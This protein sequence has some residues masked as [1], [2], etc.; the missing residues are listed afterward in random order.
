M[1]MQLQSPFTGLDEIVEENFPL[2]PHTWYRI[3]G[4]A[5]YFVRPKSIEQLQQTAKRCAENSIPIYVLGLGANLL[6]S[7]Q[8]VNGAV[9]HLDS[10]FFREISIDKNIVSVNAGYDMQKARAVYMPR[11][12]GRAWNAWREYRARSA[13]ESA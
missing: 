3:G 2:A 13:E 10:E 12:V 7:D 1:I 4:P 8:G 9:F 11:G 6:V 5:R